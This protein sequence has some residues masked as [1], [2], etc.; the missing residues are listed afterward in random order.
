MPTIIERS[1][2]ARECRITSKKAAAG[3]LAAL[4]WVFQAGGKGE[5]GFNVRASSLEALRAL[6]GVLRDVA[7]QQQQRE[8]EAAVDAGASL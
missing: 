8:R 2:A 6:P 4:E 1:E 5:S 7:A 3:D